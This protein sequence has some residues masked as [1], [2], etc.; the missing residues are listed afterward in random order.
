M[1]VVTPGAVCVGNLFEIFPVIIFP[2]G[3]TVPALLLETRIQTASAPPLFGFESIAVLF[4][5]VTSVEPEKAMPW[6]AVDTY[7][8]FSIRKFRV[9]PSKPTKPC[10]KDTIGSLRF[11][12]VVSTQI[13]FRMILF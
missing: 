3:C 5:Y 11:P 9:F 7:T 1:N 10:G 2:V 4:L 13:L 12:F 8:L 6:Y